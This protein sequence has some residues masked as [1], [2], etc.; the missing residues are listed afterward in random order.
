MPELRA[1]RYKMQAIK[2]ALLKLDNE[3]AESAWKQGREQLA[4]LSFKED[5]KNYVNSLT[6]Q[7]TTVTGKKGCHIC[8]ARCLKRCSVRCMPGE[9]QDCF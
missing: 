1:G 5:K 7:L 4:K 6:G 2:D 9:L 8:S 3:A